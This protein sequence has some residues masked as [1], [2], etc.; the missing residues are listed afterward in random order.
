MRG[1]LVVLKLGVIGA[2]LALLMLVAAACD[3]QAQPA[4][5]TTTGESP[6]TSAPTPTTDGPD[7]SRSPSPDIELAAE[8]TWV[9][10]LLDGRPVIEDSAIT[11]RIGDDWF[12]GIDGCNSYG[13]QSRDGT[14]VV[15]ADGVF[16]IPP[17]VVVTQMLCLEPEGVMDQADAYMSAFMQGKRYRVPGER[18]E[19]LD[20]EDEVR[21]VFIRQ[22]RRLAARPRII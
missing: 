15:G 8:G 6:G 21:L 10:E 19:I 14:P 4:G 11:L 1:R 7:V 22:A 16:K 9:L 18:L 17:G 2:L 12:D 3:E 5:S 20:G 13:G